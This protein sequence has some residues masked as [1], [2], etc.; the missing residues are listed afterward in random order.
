MGSTAANAVRLAGVR[1]LKGRVLN[2]PMAGTPLGRVLFALWKTLEKDDP[3]VGVTTFKTD[4]GADYW[5][6]R[7]R[8]AELAGYIADKTR[9]TRPEE[10]TAAAL[11]SEA[12]KATTASGAC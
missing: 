7:L 8:Y 3:K 4:V 5:P 12:L 1:D 6:Q 11:L 10:S 2:G 9:L